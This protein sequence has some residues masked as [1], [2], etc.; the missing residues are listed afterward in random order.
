MNSNLTYGVSRRS[1]MRILGAASAAAGTFPAFAAMQQAE[2]ADF[3]EVRWANA[4]CAGCSRFRR[5]PS[6]S[7][8]MKIRWARRSLR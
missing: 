7:V 8:R 4:V 3:V 1:F 2:H 6:L 5:T